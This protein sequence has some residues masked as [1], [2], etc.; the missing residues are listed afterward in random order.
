MYKTIYANP[1]LINLIKQDRS[2]NL[3]ASK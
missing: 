2:F 3:R 1:N